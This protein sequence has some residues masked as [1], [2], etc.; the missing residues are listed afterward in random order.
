MLSLTKRRAARAHRAGR[1]AEE[2]VDRVARENGWTPLAANFQA[3]GGELDRIYLGAGHLIVVEVRYR[4]RSDYGHAIETVTWTKRGRIVR[5][6]QEFLLRNP[7]YNRYAVR[8]DVVGVDAGG[9]L[10]WI[11]NAFQAG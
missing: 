4:S 3:R 6:T 5:S 9:T 8:F 2:A 1:K 7:Q 11:E 10:D